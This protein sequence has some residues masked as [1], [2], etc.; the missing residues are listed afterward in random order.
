MKILKPTTDVPEYF[1]RK[2]K[3]DYAAIYQQILKLRADEWLPVEF[4]KL[5]RT[6]HSFTTTLQRLAR[7]EG[8]RIVTRRDKTKPPG[9]HIYLKLLRFGQEQEK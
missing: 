3:A 7:R 9:S 5:D 6:I 4:N 1:N 2:T 8:Y